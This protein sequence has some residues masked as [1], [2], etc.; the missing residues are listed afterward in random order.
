MNAATD[1]ANEHRIV[2]LGYEATSDV[3]NVL[4]EATGLQPDFIISDSA[5]QFSQNVQT[6]DVV[7]VASNDAKDCVVKE[8]DDN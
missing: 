2:T 7:P 5:L 6:N 3:R 4:I 1:G 8:V